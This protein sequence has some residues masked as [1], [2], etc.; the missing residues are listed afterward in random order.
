MAD[1]PAS[2]WSPPT[3]G[4]NMSDP[5]TQTDILDEQNAELVAIET[6][7]GTAPSGSFA[8]VKLRLEDIE[9]DVAAVDAVADAALPKAGGTMTGQ[10]T[11]SGDPTA[12]G[13][14]ARKFYV[15]TVVGDL[16]AS[17][18]STGEITTD[19]A[20]PTS[21]TNA[22]VVNTVTVTDPAVSA[23]IFAMGHVNYTKTV[24]TDVFSVRL[25]I[26]GVTVCEVREDNAGGQTASSGAVVGSETVTAGANRTVVLHLVRVSGTGTATVGGGASPASGLHAF[27]IPT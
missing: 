3:R 26:N 20:G 22:L 5:V 12:S 11:A 8:T 2:I 1:Y 25:I 19:S 7:L 10:I 6:E 27:A 24:S 4:T 17:L 21:G 14:L 9:A 13:H 23:R 16:E 15:D 18:S